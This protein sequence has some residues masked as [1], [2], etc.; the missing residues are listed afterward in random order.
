M[1]KLYHFPTSVC[2]IKVRLSLAEIGLEYEETLINLPKGEQHEPEYLALNPDG[3][4]PTLIDDDLV[5]VESSLILEYLDRQ[6]NGAGLMPDGREGEVAARGWL[7]RTL[8]VHA[9]INSLT[10]ST[11]ARDLTLATKTPDEIKAA[12]DKMPDPIF[13]LKRADLTENGLVSPF[14]R[15]AL[16][17]LRRTFA[18]MDKTLASG[19]WIT[20]MD[21]G[22]A[23]VALLSY[24]DRLER[25]GFEGLWADSTPR[26]GDWL[27]RMQDRPSYELAVRRQIDEDSAKRTRQAAEK[28]W[29]ALAR[30][31]ASEG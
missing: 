17:V 15:Q 10:F 29:P 6:Y 19:P 13:R 30:L 9:A 5:I 7:L 25:L 11:G 14:V 27:L 4:V 16:Q 28:H 26:I 24:I 20:G 21:H 2:S 3:V 8:S 22:I 18:D 1:L 23:D 31:W 12:L